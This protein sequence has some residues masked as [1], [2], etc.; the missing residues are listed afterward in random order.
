MRIALL[1]FENVFCSPLL[2]QSSYCNS[3]EV[4]P[5]E[6]LRGMARYTVLRD[7]AYRYSIV[8]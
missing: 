8:Y 7:L 3:V 2:F 6:E 4:V 1:N 5:W